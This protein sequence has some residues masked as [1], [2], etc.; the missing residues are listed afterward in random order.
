[1]SVTRFI[2][3]LTTGLNDLKT[4]NG[5]LF[6]VE[7]SNQSTEPQLTTRVFCT[8]ELKNNFATTV[9]N[10]WQVIKNFENTIC[11]MKESDA[12]EEVA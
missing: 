11:D 12:F 8:A 2:A 4:C 6:D 9:A 1:M 10:L 5:H 7:N 3:T